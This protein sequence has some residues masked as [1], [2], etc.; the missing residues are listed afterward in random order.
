QIE[1]A[2]FQ[3]QA[4]RQSVLVTE[5]PVVE[6][7][8]ACRGGL[9]AFARLGVGAC[10]PGLGPAGTKFKLERLRLGVHSL[11]TVT[12]HFRG[13]VA[14]AAEAIVNIA[15]VAEDIAAFG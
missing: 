11:E 1:A 13:L 10:L 6:L 9:L 15:Q 7:A 14:I 2:L 4:L 8:H 5:I 3:R 12:D